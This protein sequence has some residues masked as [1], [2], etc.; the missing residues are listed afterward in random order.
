MRRGASGVLIALA[1]TFWVVSPA[2]AGLDETYLKPADKKSWGELLLEF[3]GHPGF[4]KSYALVVGI[5]K[6][7]DFS[8]LPTANDPL[9]MRDFL[10]NEAGF[11]YVHVLTDEK[12]TKARIEELMV[13]VL[14]GMIR[15][16]DQFLFYWSGHGTQRPYALGG[17]IGY[18]PLASS[19]KVSYASMISMGDIQRW[20]EV[21]AARQAL[22]LLDACFSGLAGVASK[23]DPRE[24][25][26][27]QLDKP[28][29]HLVSAGTAEEETI[30]GDRW[31]GSIFTDAV[32]RAVRGEADAKT[33]YPRDGVVSLSEL[34]GY[35]KTRVAIEAP[36]VGWTR[37]ITPQPY[38][39]RPSPGEFF[40]L[41]KERKVAKLERAGAQYQG[42]FEYGVPVVVMRDTEEAPDADPYGGRDVTIFN[43][44]K[45]SII[46]KDFEQFIAQ[47]PES[48]FVSYARNRLTMLMEGE[49]FPAEAV[50]PDPAAAET[51]LNLRSEDRAVV[52]EALSALG[53]DTGGTDGIFGAN[54]RRA[55]IGWQRG[56]GDEPTGYLTAQ[57]YGELIVP[58]FVSNMDSGSAMNSEFKGVVF[59]GT[60]RLIVNVSS[61]WILFLRNPE[62]YSS[63]AVSGKIF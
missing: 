8:S 47:F 43:A 46:A 27:D 40:F 50:P 28:A 62:S 38:I 3:V 45:D 5:S 29:H 19:A 16:N 11:D 1:A 42:R 18:L 39:L 22:F 35:V 51:A 57:Q 23:S 41:T 7:D 49:P 53:F 6:F 52:Q 63:W 30:A 37:P 13:D 24:L 44:I 9:R 26:I 58:F 32:L 33:S 31:G 54:T 4:G 36:A 59:V 34:I 60:D 15:D 12:A 21:L 56:R 48:V 61:S 20:D 10:L 25:Q 55:I 14:P 17:Q 2:L